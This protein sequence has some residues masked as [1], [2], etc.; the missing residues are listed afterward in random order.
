M[1]E[2]DALDFAGIPDSLL[3]REKDLR[4]DI[5]YY[6]KKRQDEFSKGL[7][8]TD[9]AVLEI[10]STLFDLNQSYDSL[11]AFLET[12]Y[13]DYYQLKYDLSTISLK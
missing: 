9:S 10:S 7:S 1:Q 12:E 4:V 13:P 3:E 6:D 5:T 11:K 2:A 8:E